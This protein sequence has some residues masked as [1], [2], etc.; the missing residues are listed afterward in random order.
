MKETEKRLRSCRKR[1]AT[2]T[3]ECTVRRSRSVSPENLGSKRSRK[4]K[5]DTENNRSVLCVSSSVA[6]KKQRRVTFSGELEIREFDKC[7]EWEEII[8]D[9][10][11]QSTK[12]YNLRK[13][14]NKQGLRNDHS[15]VAMDVL[16]VG[17]GSD[18]ISR[19]DLLNDANEEEGYQEEGYQTS[20]GLKKNKKKKR[21]EKGDQRKQE[22]EGVKIREES[23]VEEKSEDACDVLT[24]EVIPISQESL[25][26]EHKNDCEEN[27]NTMGGEEK[28]EKAE[29]VAQETVKKT[30]RR[31]GKEN[32]KLGHTK[33]EEH[34]D[35][36]DVLEINTRTET[37]KSGK[38][39]EI[40]G[41]DEN[42]DCSIMKRLCIV[43]SRS[44]IKEEWKRPGTEQEIVA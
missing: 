35:S 30:P 2:E 32:I 41:I 9:D 22:E 15:L 10:V 11:R 44:T 25:V 43:K 19:M 4:A 40:I 27:R 34:F 20:G 6:K 7:K 12:H 5:C 39:D 14:F 16:S 26:N 37:D 42:K 13:P 17:A 28:R 33:K 31:A 21:L 1:S 23:G 18:S 38:Q 29:A 3:A 24:S 8:Q 36:E